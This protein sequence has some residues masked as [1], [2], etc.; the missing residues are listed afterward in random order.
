MK[1]KSSTPPVAPQ[2]PTILTHHNEERVDAYHWIKNIKDPDTLKYIKAEN[3]YTEAHLLPLETLREKIFKELKKTV[4]ENDISAPILKK[5]W[6]YFSKVQKGQQYRV[7]FRKP[8]AGGKSQLLLDC[9]LL[10]K[11]KKYFSLGCFE[12]SPDQNWLAYGCDFSGNETY[13]IF[14]K[15]LKTQKLHQ[16]KVQKASGDIVWANDNQ[17]LYYT[18]LDE[19]HRPH[20]VLRFQLGS[21]AKPEI[22]FSESDQQYFVSVDKTSDEQWVLISTA[23]QITSEIWFASANEEKP[24]FRCVQVRQEAHEYSVDARAGVF[25]IHSNLKAL[26]FRLMVTPISKPEMKNWVEFV[27]EDKDALLQGTLLFQNH[28]V[29][30]RF[31]N[32]LP[33]VL[34]YNFESEKYTQLKFQEKAFLVNSTF[35]SVDAPNFV[36]ATAR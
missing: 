29:L 1:S 30:S 26:N 36:T 12:I 34:I 20:Q 25:Y 21:K 4:N 13:T 6:I 5:D 11:G 28:L 14:F 16:T 8:K 22:V 35:C 3:K 18:E 31:R 10:A 23:G 7:Y 9:N 19:N 27:A 15:N 2:K 24:R 33:E 32:A 17:T